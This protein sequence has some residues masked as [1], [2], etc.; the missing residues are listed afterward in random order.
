MTLPVVPERQAC[1][2][3]P[4][5]LADHLVVSA[6]VNFGD[7]ISFADELMLDDVYELEKQADPMVL[8][9]STHGRH[10]RVMEG[11]ELGT[12]GAKVAIDSAVTLMSPDGKTFE[13]IIL[14]EI[15]Q[16]MAAAIYVLPLAHLTVRT[17]YTLVGIDKENARTKFAEA[18]CVAF[19]RGTH[20]TMASGAQVPI[21]DL[22]VG[23]KVL[24][25][26]DGPQ[27][28]RWIGQN[29][30]RAV[31]DFA[32]VLIKAG[33]LNNEGDLIVSPDHR[34][35]IYQRDDAIGAGRSEVLV[36]VRHLINGA[37]IKRIEGG[38][39]D[40]FQ[41]LFDNHQIIYAEGIAAESMLVDPRT[42]AVL[43]A[44]IDQSLAQ[45]LPGHE[46]AQHLAYEVGEALLSEDAAEKLRRAST[47]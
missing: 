12:V 43:P 37:S 8:N 4:V 20:I 6:G 32:P 27:E 13:A 39:V 11:S 35:F 28:I 3:L 38:F 34:L 9:V 45:A 44:E 25:R 2:A 29:T 17:G 46:D 16:D 18:A 19:T 22:K 21:Q 41:L 7:G 24:T 1:Q 33:T 42:R 23:D 15:E 40:Y 10:L 31:G 14:V 26:D 47:R 36:K 5:Y 30:R